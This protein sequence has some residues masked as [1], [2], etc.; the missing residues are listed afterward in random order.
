MKKVKLMM[1][2]LSMMCLV[3]M[4]YGQTTQIPDIMFETWLINNGYDSGAPDGFVLTSNIN[5]IY[6]LYLWGSNISDL[7]GI[8]DFSNLNYLDCGNNSISNLNITQ[9]QNLTY[10][11]CSNNQLGNLFLSINP[12]LTYLDCRSNQ[13]IN[14]DVTQNVNLTHLDCSYNQ[15]SNLDVTQNTNLTDLYCGDNQLN[16]LNVTQNVNLTNLGCGDNQLNN[17]DVTLNPNLTLLSCANN[18]LYNI[19]VTQNTNL[20]DLYCH[21]NQLYSLNLSQNINLS[22]LTCSGNNLLNCLNLKNGNNINLNLSNLS[23]GLGNLTCVEVDDSNYSTAN[24]TNISSNIYFS[25]NCN[26]NCS[27]GVKEVLED[28]II[29]YPN[30]TT[31]KITISL[32]EYKNVKISIRNSIGQIVLSQ[33]TF[34]NNI[35]LNLIYPKG[36]YF[37]QIEIDKQIIH[38]T[39]IKS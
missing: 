34:S 9:N 26:N 2:T 23:W 32:E 31:D 24:W 38:K 25:E 27:V 12:N 21:N 35:N 7:T 13:L 18:Q 22:L 36:L 37:L 11:D 4:S 17:I 30:P 28:Y 15:L 5:T 14:I 1:I 16:S 39:I 8:Q 10:L 29:I 33:E 6:G 20:T 19:N 3:G